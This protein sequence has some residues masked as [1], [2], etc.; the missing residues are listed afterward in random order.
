MIP[1][2]SIA[3]QIKSFQVHSMIRERAIKG[4][5]T[6]TDPDFDYVLYELEDRFRQV[7]AKLPEDW[8][9]RERFNKTLLGLERQSSPGYPLCKQA[10]TIDQWLYKGK[11][12][13]DAHRA[14]TLWLMVQSVFEGTY[15]HIFKVFIKREPHTD[16][17]AKQGRW[18]LI[19]A[20]SLP[21]QVAWHMAIEHLEKSFLKLYKSP[22]MHGLTYYGGGWRWFA[23]YAKFNNLKWCADKSGWDWNS[24]YWVYKICL[25]LRKN[26]TTGATPEWIRVLE[27]LYKDAYQES[28]V[29]LPDGTI[30]KQV[31]WGL[32]KS[33]LVPTISDNGICQVAIAILALKI[34]A[35]IKK[36][37]LRHKNMVSTGDDTFEEIP[38]D[39]E[40]YVEVM[41]S[42]GCVIKQ[43]GIGEEFMGFRVTEEGI[44]PL[45]LAKHLK[46]LEMQKVEFLQETIEGYMRM[47]AHDADLF[48]FFETLAIKL[49]FSMPSRTYFRYFMDNPDALETYTVQ[50]PSF[51]DRYEGSSVAS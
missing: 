31:L 19:M 48:Q 50:R 6:V 25:E 37:R 8:N 17:K 2:T 20:T 30:L 11:P 21:V 7:R 38:D 41:Q 35:R 45:Y 29:I 26:L 18:R 40:L 16:K 46:N 22:L 27:L 14:E 49:G 13:P 5:Q 43:Y 1:D 36:Q 10:P 33:G 3:A 23:E 9:S 24:P 12:F 28:K 34:I 47:Y 15:D 4:Y 42:L 51:R 39:E 44:E 32:M